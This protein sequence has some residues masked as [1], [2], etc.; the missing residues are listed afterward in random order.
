MNKENGFTLVEMLVTT[1]IFSLVL[2]AIY[3]SF[4]TS[5]NAWNKGE[6]RMGLYQEARLTL[7]DLSR[8]LRTAFISPNPNQAIEFIGTDQ[9]Q[10]IGDADT[11]SFF[12]LPSWSQYNPSPN[13]KPSPLLKIDLFMEYSLEQDTFFLYK[14]ETPA[15]GP[16]AGQERIRKITYPCSGL[17]FRYYDGTNWLTEWQSEGSLPRAVE[18]IF[19]LQDE[20]KK[21]FTFK[22]SILIPAGQEYN[23]Q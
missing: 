6:E 1:L 2:G 20:A 16:E 13:L 19:I 4:H 11:L 21:K 14:K 12:T 8:E 3:F 18:V 5:L 17:N 22:N 15:Y 7:N 23:F 9:R 10:E